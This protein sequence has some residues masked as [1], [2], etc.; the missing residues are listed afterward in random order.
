V[1]NLVFV[2]VWAYPLR[3]LRVDLTQQREYSLSRATRDL[4]GNLQEPL[5]VRG[6]F[7][8]KTHP[9]LA[10][11]VP[12]IRDMLQ[13]Y[14]VASGG[15]VQLE[16]VDPATDPEKEAEANQTYGIRPTPFQVTDRYEASVINSYF[17]VLIRYGDQ[18]AV[19]TFDDLIEVVPRRDG[20]DVRLRNLEY[21]L[22]RSIKKVVYG[23]QSIDA[24]LAALGAPAELTLYLTPDALPEWLAE[25]PATI[26]QVAGDIAG[27]AGGKFAYRTVNPDAP[28]SPVT[29]QQLYD[30]YGLQPFAASL[31][32]NESYYFHMVLTIG[33]QAQVIYPQGDLS[34][35]E[36]RTAIEAA[37]KRASSGFLQVVGLWTPPAQPTL[38]S[39][40]QTQ[41]PLASWQ[42]V[43]ETLGQEY[44]VRPVDLSTGQVE[45]DVDVLVVI[46][47]KNM[48]D[49]ERFAVD[50]YL[51][52]GGSV[53]VAA[54]NY[55]LIPD[56]M[57]G[58][59]GLEPVQNGLQ[60]MLASYGITITQALVLDP[61]NEPFPVPV[62]R[63][64]GDY[65]V[66][67]IQS[68]DYPFFVDVRSDG[69]AADE[70]IGA[71]NPIVSNLPAVT[72]NFASPI[73]VD[74][75]K[76][77][78]RQVK[79]LLRSSPG[80]WTQ[81]DTNIQPN[82][83]LYPQAGFP[84][85]DQPQSY[86][87]AVAVQG[88]FESAFKGQPAPS[89]GGEEGGEVSQQ[90]TGVI[91]TSPDTARLVVVGSG[92]FLDDIIFR[93]SSALTQ[94][95]YLNSLQF[96][97]NAVSWS[98]EDLDLLSIRSRGTYARVLRPM[99]EHE[100]SLWEGANYVLALLALVVIGVVWNLR[101]R[102]EV[103]MELVAPGKESERETGSAEVGR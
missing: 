23:F 25:V 95:R 52:R 48:T 8:E 60:E 85:G 20:V 37:L 71:D 97:Q 64:V 7:S 58:G 79:V 47:P 75:V 12:T 15:K 29:R 44:E 74:E 88:V 53:V 72:V 34:E 66:Q 46:A 10:P 83:E 39:F 38:D 9:L 5:L 57:T 19:L 93:I 6:Y 91:E 67:E 1:L 42:Q 89:A 32:S 17:D 51:M 14:Q 41:Q 24:V 27:K 4:L 82:F 69:M 80:S 92:E 84:A 40:G 70:Y 98:T 96:L 2:N 3:N 49:Q 56:P 50:Q 103:P 26:E 62:V 31:F 86:V 21:D 33:D 13:E 43:E 35:A 18:S 11:L 30:L 77:A 54:G 90:S 22:T 61:Q 45:A 94:D 76:N 78:D 65:Q 28:D 16:I 81:S 100:Q 55:S 36:I 87:L 101:T 99:S 73:T 68:L 63:Q 59:L 102:N